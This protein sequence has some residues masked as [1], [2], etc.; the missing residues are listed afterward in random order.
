MSLKLFIKMENINKIS[1]YNNGFNLNQREKHLDNVGLYDDWKKYVW[2]LWNKNWA[3]HN[4][5]DMNKKWQY[6]KSVKSTKN[7]NEYYLILKEKLDKIWREI[8]FNQFKFLFN[9]FVSLYHKKN[10]WRKDIKKQTITE[11]I[12]NFK[13]DKK[14]EKQEKY[15]EI[16]YIKD[17]LKASFW[18][19]VLNN[20]REQYKTLYNKRAEKWEDIYNIYEIIS[21]TIGLLKKKLDTNVSEHEEEL[22]RRYIRF[23]RHDWKVET[24]GL[25]DSNISHP[26]KPRQL[27]IPFED[28]EKV[29]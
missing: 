16:N 12:K 4:F 18:Y 9:S 10:S 8:S 13:D 17:T 2:L 22:I 6:S 3:W 23:K 1:E 27:D 20:I 11:V 15:K 24:I 28:V 29:A 21:E 19:D 26:E 25:E 5:V 14:T 7:N